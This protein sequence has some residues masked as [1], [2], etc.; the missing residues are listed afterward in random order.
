MSTPQE[1]AYAI[2][3]VRQFMLELLDASKTPRVPR[4]VRERAHRLVKH[5]P[6]LPSL[7]QAE[8]ALQRMRLR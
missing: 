5:F 8:K 7:E 4:Y 1:E 3:R 6:L 2:A